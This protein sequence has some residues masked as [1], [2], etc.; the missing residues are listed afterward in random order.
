MT[1]LSI[2]I[3]S[4]KEMFLKNT[5]DDILKNIRADTEIIV[6][7]DG[8][9]PEIGIE[10]N[11]KINMI[12]LPRS[13]GQRAA[14]N[15][16]AKIAQ[17]E[18]LMKVDAHCAFAKGFDATMLQDIAPDVTMAPLMQNLHAFDWVCKDCNWAEYQGPTPE[19][20]KCPEC[21]SQNIYREILWR[22]KIKSRTAK[23]DSP[24]STSY[25]FNKQLEFK[26]FGAYRKKQKGDIVE[27]MS[28]QGSCFMVHRDKYW[29]LKL[30]DESYGSWGGQGAEV[31]LKTWLSGGRVL[32]NTKT[33]YAHLFRTQGGD[34]G[35]P[36]PNPGKDQKRAKDNLR[37]IFL[38][39][40][41][42]HAIRPLSWLVDK[43]APVPDWHD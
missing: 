10:T 18:Y 27:T 16:A 30:C 37:D 15:M 33:W 17:G 7:L 43:F 4:R 42:E 24:K 19:D 14:T 1:D 9:W 22:P 36:Y 29:G 2:L 34:F 38:N 39:D 32:V 8:S 23:F 40:K 35:F 12:Y 31:A 28:L 21:G 26:Y 13:I 11:G 41:W 5:V 6:A 20:S 25:R 3:P